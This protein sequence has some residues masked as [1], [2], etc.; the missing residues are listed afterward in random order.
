MDNILKYPQWQEP[1]AAALVELDPKLLQEK[2]KHV[3][4]LIGKRLDELKVETCADEEFRALYDGLSLIR[5]FKKAE[6][7]SRRSGLYR[8]H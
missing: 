4:Q 5:S 6:S 8:V 2:L 1:L 7:Q 3:A